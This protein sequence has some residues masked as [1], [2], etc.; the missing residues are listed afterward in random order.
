MLQRQTTTRAKLINKAKVLNSRQ[1]TLN[2]A[3]DAAIAAAADD[4]EVQ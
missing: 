2:S 3:D 1:L 4:D